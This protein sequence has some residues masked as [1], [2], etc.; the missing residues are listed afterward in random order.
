MPQ[1][2]KTAEVGEFINNINHL[3]PSKIATVA[4]GALEMTTWLANPS[5]ALP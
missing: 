5:L 1:T 3:L 4:C 2:A